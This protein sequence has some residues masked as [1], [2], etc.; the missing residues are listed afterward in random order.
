MTICYAAQKTNT[1]HA[2]IIWSEETCN[3]GCYFNSK[4]RYIGDSMWPQI[5]AAFSNPAIF[6]IMFRFISLTPGSVLNWFET[7]RRK[8]TSSTLW[9]DIINILS[10][11]GKRKLSHYF[12]S[13]QWKLLMDLILMIHN[14][15]TQRQL[16]CSSS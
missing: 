1:D 16:L 14:R 6:V 13:Q 8:K 7:Q 15:F 3:L 2:I 11:L 9:R 12:S 10:V 4:Q 5:Q